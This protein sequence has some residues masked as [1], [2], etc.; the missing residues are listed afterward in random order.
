MKEKDSP[1]KQKYRRKR[2]GKGSRRVREV[3][4]KMEER[5]EPIASRKF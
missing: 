5:K 1:K 2:K 4:K 3:V